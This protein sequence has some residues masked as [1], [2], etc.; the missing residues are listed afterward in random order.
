VT[1]QSF[2]TRFIALA[3]VICFSGCAAYRI[4]LKEDRG[5]AEAVK[6]HPES[7]VKVEKQNSFPEGLQCFE[8]ML[9]VLTV[10]LV[11]VDCVDT[12]KVFVPEVRG[13]R[14]Y[15]VREMQGWVT[16]FL[17]PLP[18]WHYGF[19]RKPEPEIE[20]LARSNGQ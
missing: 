5:L 2:Q 10:G 19:A 13:E 8:P 17:L 12:Y 7:A 18:H 14:T 20:Q 6:A 9:F 16:L 4:T 11:P 1:T 15:T 3:L